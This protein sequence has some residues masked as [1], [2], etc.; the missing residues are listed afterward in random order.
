MPQPL[1]FIVFGVPRSGTKA[2]AR[3]LNLHPNILCTSERFDYRADH[4]QLSFPEDFLDHP[5]FIDRLDWRKIQVA[6]A[7]AAAKPD[8]RFVGN[9]LPRY[10]LALDRL[11][12]ELPVLRN[13]AIYRSPYEFIPSWNRKEQ[14]RGESRWLAGDIGLYGFLDLLVC[15]RNVARQPRAFLFPYRHGLNESAEPMLAAIDFIGAD[16]DAFD[17]ATFVERV[18]PK[19][20]T[21]PRRIPLEAYEVEFL[22]RL[23]VREL[24]QLVEDSWGVVT[25]SVASRLEDYLGS[26]EASLPSAIDEAFAQCGNPAARAY[27]ARY[28]ATHRS[29]LAELLRMTEGSRFVAGLSRFGPAQ[30]LGF[31]ASQRGLLK[32]RLRSIRIAGKPPP[33]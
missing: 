4:S 18:L 26:I 29:E 5:R 31:V 28:V 33:D 21:N 20:I 22:D 2:L 17:G 13:L 30:R 27:G 12:F 9:K 10:Y 6:R 23:N 19:R 16:P 11:N 1:S 24:D 3:G 14:A 25:P 8:V 32:R 15:L 7:M